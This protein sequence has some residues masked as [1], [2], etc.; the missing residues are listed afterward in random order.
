[1]KRK[2]AVAVLGIAVSAAMV[3]KSQAQGF[4][5]FCNYAI[6]DTGGLIGA[7]V[8]YE[9]PSYNGLFAGEAVGTGSGESF[10]ASL[11]YQYGAN[12]GTFNWTDSG[13]TASF[14]APTGDTANGAGFFGSRANS[15]AIPGYTFGPCNFI[16][17]V[18]NGSSYSAVNS[19]ARGQSG[20]VQLSLLATSANLLPVG[21]LLSDNPNATMPLTAFT[22]TTLDIPPST[23]EPG[24]FALAGLGAAGFMAMHRKKA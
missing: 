4:V 2:L 10:T 7:P 1:M 12:L 5:I 24:M 8:T 13:A 19:T 3:A 23:P 22:T 17:Q 18:Y 9:G 15:V 11:L 14:L 6:N 21:G 20:V 16:V